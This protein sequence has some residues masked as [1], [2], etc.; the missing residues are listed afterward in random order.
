MNYRCVVLV[1]GFCNYGPVLSDHIINKKKKKKN[2]KMTVK[3][4][5]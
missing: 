2:M 4:S 1:I 5:I 3:Q